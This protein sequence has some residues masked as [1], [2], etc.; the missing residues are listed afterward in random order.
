MNYIELFGISCSGKTHFKQ[1]IITDLKNKKIQVSDK[2]QIIILFYLNNTKI[3]LLNYIK[4]SVL[5]I[6]HSR[7]INLF[8]FLFQT[9]K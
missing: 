9:K 4:S 6:Y 2:K 7:F 3:G 5:L 8:K 1:K